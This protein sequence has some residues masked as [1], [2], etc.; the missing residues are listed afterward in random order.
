M[1]TLAE[2]RQKNPQYGD[3]TD[4]QLADGLYGKY[5]S[6]IPRAEFD[7]KIGMAP[8]GI[9]QAEPVPTPSGAPPVAQAAATP[10]AASGASLAEQLAAR[11]TQEDDPV[12][13]DC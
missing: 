11:R 3:M 7:A 6:D 4:Q 12:P 1:A 5:Y 13:G 8:Q 10:A 2:I 9:V